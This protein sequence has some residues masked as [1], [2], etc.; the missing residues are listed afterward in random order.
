MRE[1]AAFVEDDAP[2]TA[3]H[4][5]RTRTCTAVH[6]G[7]IRTSAA[8]RLR[9]CKASQKA[10]GESIE[11]RVAYGADGRPIAPNPAFKQRGFGT[12]SW[13]WCRGAI[14]TM[15]H[16]GDAHIAGAEAPP[17]LRPAL[18]A[19]PHAPHAHETAVI[20]YDP[21]VAH[22]PTTASAAAP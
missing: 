6:L 12:S 1:T 5:G 13:E 18:A 8:E 7:R 14:A 19:H 3:V 20:I 21:T 22:Y 17:E 10:L 11:R 2:L 15:A 16:K 4:L 9:R